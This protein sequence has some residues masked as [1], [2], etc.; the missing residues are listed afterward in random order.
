MTRFLS[1]AKLITLITSIIDLIV[2]LHSAFTA[3]GSYTLLMLADQFT[4]SLFSGLNG[5]D[6]ESVTAG[7]EV[8]G[9]I[10]GGTFSGFFELIIVLLVAANVVTALWF[11]FPCVHGF[12]TYRKN[13]TEESVL[14][15]KA[16]RKDAVIKLVF[17]ILPLIILLASKIHTWPVM[18][19]LACVC[20]A[21][22][23]FL[24][25]TAE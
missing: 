5:I 6:P 8:L 21:E 3:I 24:Y 23:Y 11:I 19:C 4:I 10:F 20:G 7:Y 22:G 16:C 25:E 17:N 12:L 18:I 13:S 15:M 1:Q 9:R 2:L 14:F